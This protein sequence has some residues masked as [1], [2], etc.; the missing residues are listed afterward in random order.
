MT[1]RRE[2]APDKSQCEGEGRGEGEGGGKG[3]KVPERKKEQK[4]KKRPAGKLGEIVQRWSTRRVEAWGNGA[5]GSEVRGSGG[6]GRKCEA[7]EQGGKRGM[8]YVVV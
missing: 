7:M 3:A 1:W 5:A 6:T 4:K 2:N 8:L